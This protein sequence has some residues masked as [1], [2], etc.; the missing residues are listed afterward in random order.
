MSPWRLEWYRLVRTRRLVVLVGV[1]LLFGFMGPLSAYYFE[2][3]MRRF[4]GELQIVAPPPTVA[5]AIGQFTANG[6][7]LGM[8]V[9]L[10]VA[11]GSLNLHQRPELAFFLRTRVPNATRLLL[12]RFVVVLLA[13][14][15]AFTAGTLAAWYETVLLIGTPSVSGMLA[16]IALGWIYLAFAIAVV[17]VAA[18]VA[19]STVTAVALSAG[20]LL[21]LPLLAIV[22]VIGTWL[23]S[24]LIGALPALAAG[25]DA[26]EYLAA[27][28]VTLVATGVAFAVAV[29]RTA[30]REI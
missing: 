13:A 5:D 8:L 11:A 16:G 7:Q 23:P 15:V 6:T 10:I 9:V 22:E 17:A 18:S 14:G 30:A 28:I 26:G 19:S 2:E 29:R 3:I 27:A 20:V 24:R 25:Q 1:F 12:P 4:G 21:L